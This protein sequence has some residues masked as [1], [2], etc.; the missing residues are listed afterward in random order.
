MT[1]DVSESYGILSLGTPKQLDL[2]QTSTTITV[3]PKHI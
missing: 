2:L 3:Y 1:P